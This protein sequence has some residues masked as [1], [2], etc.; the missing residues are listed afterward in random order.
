MRRTIASLAA[1]AVFLAPNILSPAAVGQDRTTGG[2]MLQASLSGGATGDPDGSGTAMIIAN[3]GQRTI[4]YELQVSGIDPATA[5]HIHLLAT[6]AIVV[7]LEAP[8]GGT[9][10]GCVENLDRALVLAILKNPGA[11]YVNVHN[12]EYPGGAV[13]GTLG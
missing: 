5:S 1:A 10:E 2:R 9:A 6:G 12:A 4:C 11:Y 3:P 7:P 13:R 8:T